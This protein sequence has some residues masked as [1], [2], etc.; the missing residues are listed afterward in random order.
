MDQWEGFGV[1]VVEAAL[2]GKPAVVSK[3]S[4]LVE[5]IIDGVTGIGVPEDDPRATATAI[6]SLLTN[7]TLCREMGATARLQALAG[8]TWNQNSSLV[9][10]RSSLKTLL[11]KVG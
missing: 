9:N 8:R 11:V 4:G 2:C 6:L 1:A 10:A 5:A 7:Q 3:N